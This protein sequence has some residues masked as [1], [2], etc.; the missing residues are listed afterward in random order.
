MQIAFEDISLE[1]VQQDLLADMVE[2]ERTIAPEARRAF[3]LIRTMS[4]DFLKHP[5]LKREGV[6]P[7]DLHELAGW[8]LLRQGITSQGGEQYEVTGSGRQY[9]AWV[10]QQR[11]EPV[12]QVEAEVRRLL[13]AGTFRDH[14]PR[15]YD[16]WAEAETKVWDADTPAQ[17]TDLGHACRE[18]IQL[19]VTDL[20]ERYEP[21]EV[22]PDPQK[23]IDR[24]RAVAGRIGLPDAVEEFAYALLAYFGTVSDLVQ[25]Q[26]HGAQKEGELLR[27]EDA[28]R[29]VFQT[30]LVMFEL[31]RALG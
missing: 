14:H 17:F 9:Y 2:A 31:D 19:F 21:P 20:V 24:L 18:A 6:Y 11:G 13:D 16:R 27:W 5:G 10:K 25:R 3:L 28:R 29:V 8:G 22:N 30:A 23:T 26:E 15:A 4:G 1:K 12:E 7:G